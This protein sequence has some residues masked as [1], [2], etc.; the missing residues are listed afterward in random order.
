MNDQITNLTADIVCAHVSNNTVAVSDVPALINSVYEALSGLG[1]ART[2]ITAT[3][4]YEPGVTVRK[5]LANPD[6]IISMIDGKPYK[7][8]SRHLNTNDLTPDEYRA[9]YSLPANYPMVAPA[10]ALKRREIAIKVGLGR[11]AA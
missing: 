4:T 3:R 1:V 9:R 5:S 11:K 7:M 2:A 8:L 10:Y 6:H